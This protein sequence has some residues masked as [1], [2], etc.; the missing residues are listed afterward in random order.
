MDDHAASNIKNLED[1]HQDGLVET[2][3]EYFNC[4]YDPQLEDTAL[5]KNCTERDQYCT[6]SEVCKNY[7]FV[8]KMY[9]LPSVIWVVVIFNNVV[10]ETCE[11]NTDLNGP[12]CDKV[13][14]SD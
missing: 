11:Q 7:I 8:V 6:S 3:E 13:V 14:K 1:I 10:P 5:S 9:L 12:A 2:V 4:S